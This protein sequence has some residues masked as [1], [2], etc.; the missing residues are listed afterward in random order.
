MTQTM[1]WFG[2]ADPVRLNDIRQCGASEVVTALH[3]VP[4]GEVWTRE[5]IAA[6][7]ALVEEAGLGWTVVESLPVH[8]GIKTHGADWDRLVEAYRVS[9][10]NLAACGIRVVTYNFMPLL[11]WTRTDLAWRLPDARPAIAS[12]SASEV[13]MA[14]L[15]PALETTLPSAT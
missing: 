6:R 12:T 7:K 2:P 5:A 8:E 14:A 9:V 1:R 11:D 15:I 4:N 3:E 13:G 10:R